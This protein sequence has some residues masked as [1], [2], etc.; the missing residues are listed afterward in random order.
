MVREME[1]SVVPSLERGRDVSV[2]FFRL[3]VSTPQNAI[4]VG[5]L[6]SHFIVIMK[7]AAFRSGNR[8]GLL[9]VSFSRHVVQHNSMLSRKLECMKIMS[10]SEREK[11]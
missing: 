10:A 2:H 1:F 5:I 4:F 6:P 8:V 7:V 11:T 9:D 3:F